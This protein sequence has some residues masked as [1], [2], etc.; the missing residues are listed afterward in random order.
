VLELSKNDKGGRRNW[1]LAPESS[2][3]AGGSGSKSSVA[4]PPPSPAASSSSVALVSQQPSHS[5][6]HAPPPQAHAAQVVPYAPAPG[7][8]LNASSSFFPSWLFIVVPFLLLVGRTG[9]TFPV[10]SPHTG[11][12]ASTAAASSRDDCRAAIEAAQR[13]FPAWEQKPF[14]TRR[15]ILLR[16]A[17]TLQSEE[18]QRKAAP[19]MRAEIA[20]T[21][22]QINF[23]FFAGT[24]LLQGIACM[25]N[26]FACPAGTRPF[27]RP[28]VLVFG[29]DHPMVL[30][31]VQFLALSW[32]YVSPFTPS[33]SRSA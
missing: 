7:A 23:N 6:G 17:T 19:A 32:K 27:Q 14:A 18:W 30:G 1:S 11:E 31:N 12:L 21:Q 5:N 10:H 8:A 25:V 20:M 16:A 9:A 13:A 2:N 3:G 24:Q 26:E 28:H 15:E 33:M 29:P 4:H 22:A